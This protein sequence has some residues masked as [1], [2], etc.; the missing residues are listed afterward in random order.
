ME[1]QCLLGEIFDPEKVSLTPA[2]SYCGIDTPV[3]FTIIYQRH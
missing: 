3:N 2:D 1:S